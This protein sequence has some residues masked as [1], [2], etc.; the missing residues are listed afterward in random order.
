MGAMVAA[1]LN[2]ADVRFEE[3]S[4]VEGPRVTCVDSGEYA[5]GLAAV[6][7][8]VARSGKPE[9]AGSGLYGRTALEACQIDSLVDFVNAEFVPGPRFDVASAALNTYLSSRTYLVGHEI[10]IADLVAWQKLAS[11]SQS[12]RSRSL[13]THLDRWCKNIEIVPVVA[14]IFDKYAD[15]KSKKKKS[16]HEKSKNVKGEA[17]DPFAIELPNAVDGKV[18]TRFPPEPSG[19]LHIGHAKRR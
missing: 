12:R 16:A 18:V 6:M 15:S 8:Y 4:D 1:Q 19:Y 13:Y 9:G 11:N 5:E 10:S 7:R 2:A 14:E 17:G 3:S